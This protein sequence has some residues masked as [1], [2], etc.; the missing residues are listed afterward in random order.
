[1]KALHWCDETLPAG[2]Y[3]QEW[4]AFDHPQL[5]PIEI[6]GWKYKYI[7][8]N[9][10]PQLL[11]AEIAKNTDFALTL[12]RCL[13]RP[14]AALAVEPLGG[15]YSKVKLHLLNTGWLP[16]N[17]TNRALAT[18]A[19]R[20]GI[21]VVVSGFGGGG[22][23]DGGG[24][25]LNTGKTEQLV[26]HLAGRADHAIENPLSGP[27]ASQ[28]P[29]SFEAQL[30]WVVKGEGEFKVTADFQRAGKLTVTTAVAG[31]GASL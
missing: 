24:L 1:M 30:E 18:A 16:T 29:N 4:T 23:G 27:S 17:G 10:P 21:K 6:G 31:A 11:E 8:Q 9:P 28:G 13:P 2:S 14:K 12:A 25:E 7:W 26:P 3:F 5:G 19:V 15:G 22:G 20:K